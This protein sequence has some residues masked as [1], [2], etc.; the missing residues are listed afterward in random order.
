M[1]PKAVTLKNLYG[2]NDELS[3]EFKEGVAARIFR[4]FADDFS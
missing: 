1:N 4:N 3:N 2:F